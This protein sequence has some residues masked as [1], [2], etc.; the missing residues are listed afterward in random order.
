MHRTGYD[1]TFGFM[2]DE[3][4]A[5]GPFRVLWLGPA[6]A[7]PAGGWDL[8]DGVAYSTSIGFPSASGLWTGPEDDA[9]QLVPHAL[10]RAR[11][12]DSSRLGR[13]FGSMGIRYVVVVSQLAPAPYKG[14]SAPLPSWLD[15]VLGE[16]LDLAQLDLN[17][18]VTVYRNPSWLPMVANLPSDVQRVEDLPAAADGAP[19]PPPA[20]DSVDPDAQRFEGDVTG[21]SI[22]HLAQARNDRWRLEV[23][24]TTIAGDTGFGWANRYQVSQ[25][26]PAELRFVTTNGHRLLMAGQLVAWLV[27]AVLAVRRRRPAGERTEEAPALAAPAPAP[28]AD[29]VEVSV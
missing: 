8:G 18:A 12:G 28:T 9:A 10:D 16:Q 2:A 6:E 3:A 24:G 1:R 17:S 29:A 13:T 11:R 25:P 22:L 27:V 23:D 5:I 14:H 4:D 7:L 19:P 15:S 21:G 20:L 26:G